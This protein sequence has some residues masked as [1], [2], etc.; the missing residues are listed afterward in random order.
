MDNHPAEKNT[1]EVVSLRKEQQ[2]TSS[3]KE[4]RLAAEL[5]LNKYFLAEQK[6]FNKVEKTRKEEAEKQLKRQ[7]ELATTDTLTGLP[8]RRAWDSEINKLI[9]EHNRH[10][11]EHRQEYALLTVDIDHFK[12]INDTYG[13]SIGDIVLKETAKVLQHIFRETDIISRFGGE[14]FFIL[15]KD[16]NIHKVIERL[17]KGRES[18]NPGISFEVTTKSGRIPVHFSGGLISLI[19]TN[20]DAVQEAMKAADELLYIAKN[21]G[22]NRITT[23]Q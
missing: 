20:T 2:E 8:N 4:E 6:I 19:P 5:H 23:K 7:E 15:I 9:A 10:P 21:S 14:E 16:S 22:R 13:H 3:K 1:L 12:K 11:E 18:G 17:T